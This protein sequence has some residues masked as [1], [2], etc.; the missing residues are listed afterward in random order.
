MH[1]GFL[2]LLAGDWGFTSCFISFVS[3]SSKTSSSNDGEC[4]LPSWHLVLSSAVAIGLMSRLSVND[5]ISET[6]GEIVAD[7]KEIGSLLYLSPWHR[8]ILFAA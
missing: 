3:A 7:G 6:D 4:G 5:G 8:I 2:N 1:L